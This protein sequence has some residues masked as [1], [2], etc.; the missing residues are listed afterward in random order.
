[1]TDIDALTADET[2]FIYEAR[3]FLENPSLLIRM[4]NKV[5]KPLDRGLQ[6]L[7]QSV[8]TKIQVA[9]ESSL[10]KGLDVV[11]KSLSGHGGREFS[12]AI[13][14][15]RRVGA[16]HS[17]ASFGTGAVGGFFGVAGL[18]VELPIT[19][20]IMLR[21]IASVA[22]DFGF[23]LE[24][25]D[26]QLECLYVLSI[27]G[28]RAKSGD[29]MDSAYWT[30]RLAFT[31][32]IRQAARE[33]RKGATPLLIRFLTKVAARFQ[34]V[35]SEKVLAEIVPVVGAIGGGAINAAFTEH[36]TQAA[37]YHFGLR[38]MEKEYG[39]ALIRQ[40]YERS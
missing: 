14:R 27:G 2:H 30:S 15:S 6:A 35:V 5:G 38:A 11:T 26:I 9:V 32:L 28:E 7:P 33:V 22:Q 21:S 40:I 37:R 3:Q 4:A 10:R 12:E 8:Q 13:S 25:P 16:L 19:T 1:M 20:G 17:L 29:T 24:S 34:I 23:D 31:D 18:P 36:F 39:E